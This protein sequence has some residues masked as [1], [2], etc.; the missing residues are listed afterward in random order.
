MGTDP[1]T[2]VSVK[3]RSSALPEVGVSL[4]FTDTG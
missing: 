3:P 4:H 1:A 2:E